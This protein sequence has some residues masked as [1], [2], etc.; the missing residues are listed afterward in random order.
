MFSVRN[1]DPEFY[2]EVWVN[3]VQFRLGRDMARSV[4]MYATLQRF[5]DDLSRDLLNV[6]GG[7]LRTARARFPRH[8]EA[9]DS[10]MF[11]ILSLFD[12]L[13]R[14]FYVINFFGL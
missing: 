9:I 12:R 8:F 14:R 6:S 2:S 11:P 10:R 1:S 7:N 5:F 3:I 4:R 13:V